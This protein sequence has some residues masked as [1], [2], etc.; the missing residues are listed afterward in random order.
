MQQDET[1]SVPKPTCNN[2]D[3]N[4]ISNFNDSDPR[5]T[6]YT[7]G[8]IR[9]Y[10]C[11]QCPAEENAMK[12]LLIHMQLHEEGSG[13]I[14]C[15]ECGWFVMPNKLQRHNGIHH[16]HLRKRSFAQSQ[17]P[18]NRFYYQCPECNALV[19]QLSRYR[20]H[21]EMHEN[22]LGRICEEEGCGWLVKEIGRHRKRWHPEDEKSARQKVKHPRRIKVMEK[23]STY[24]HKYSSS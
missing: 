19:C 9:R 23:R 12:Y 4:I 22:G 16:E 17:K 18:P 15:P 10:G 20:E 11:R 3:K 6:K 24:L 21:E 5:C 14:P 13:A 2:N 8:N 1:P 7:R